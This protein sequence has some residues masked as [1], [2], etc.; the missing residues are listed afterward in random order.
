VWGDADPTK[1]PVSGSPDMSETRKKSN[2]KKWEVMPFRSLRKE[3]RDHY[4][5]MKGVSQY[6]MDGNKLDDLVCVRHPLKLDT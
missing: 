4:I 6:K 1:G 3:A 5:Q 2:Y